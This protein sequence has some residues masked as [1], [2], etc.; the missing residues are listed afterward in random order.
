[1]AEMVCVMNG[2]PR[3]SRWA[4]NSFC[5]RCSTRVGFSSRSSSRSDSARAQATRGSRPVTSPQPTTLAFVSTLTYALVPAGRA[6]KP[7]MRIDE[8]R[9]ATGP[10]G[11]GWA[12]RASDAA[13]SAPPA[14][15][16]AAP[17]VRTSRRLMPG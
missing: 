16:A 4:R 6:R 14:A 12:A 13:S 10:P 5:Q 2:P 17:A 9:S 8:P 1:M 15:T 3:M 7:V 11:A